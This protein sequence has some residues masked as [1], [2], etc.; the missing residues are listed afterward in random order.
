M[1]I[2]P[3]Y[4]LI[5]CSC[6]LFGCSQFNGR[7]SGHTT[8][9][10][11]FRPSDCETI[12]SCL[13]SRHKLSRKELKA[14]TKTASQQYDQNPNASNTLELICLSLHPQ[15]GFRQFRS[16]LKLLDQYIKDHP[17]TVSG[18]QGLRYLF[19]RLNQERAARWRQSMKTS[20]EKEI[21]AIENKELTERNDRLEQTV[22]QDQTR[23]EELRQQIDQLK[24]IETIIKNRDH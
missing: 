13:N 10:I 9:T 15:A 19:Q 14:A 21:L 24:N 2:Q 5:L 12:L 17:D 22:E 6:M 11:V 23:I 20:D 7:P 16:G 18:L 4:I 3:F 8:A 1:K